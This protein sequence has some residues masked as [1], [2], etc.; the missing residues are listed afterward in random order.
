MCCF[1]TSLSGVC[2]RFDAADLY[3]LALVYQPFLQERL[4]VVVNGWCGPGVCCSIRY[5]DS[6]VTCRTE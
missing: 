3:S 4:N 5:D 2:C 6:T 1:A